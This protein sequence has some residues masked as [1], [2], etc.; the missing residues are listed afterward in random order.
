MLR[1]IK[2]PSCDWVLVFLHQYSVNQKRPSPWTH[3]IEA[4]VLAAWP[5]CLASFAA[6]SALK[7]GGKSVLKPWCCWKSWLCGPAAPSCPP[8]G[9]EVHGPALAGL[10]S[11]PRRAMEHSKDY[12]CRRA[13]SSLD[14]R[15]MDASSSVL[16]WLFYCWEVTQE[17][18]EKAKALREPRSRT[19]L[20][21]RHCAPR[22]NS[23]GSSPC[24]PLPLV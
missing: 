14:P 7:P 10:R 24:F 23:W 8:R 21:L 15:A 18:Q 13:A 4:P 19:V 3:D 20:Q 2:N 11:K 22:Q 9:V 17:Q 5:L 6:C 16:K 1:H 12:S